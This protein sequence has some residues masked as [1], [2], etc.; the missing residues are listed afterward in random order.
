MDKKAYLEALADHVYEMTEE[1]I[2][3]IVDAYLAEGYS[4]YEAI[5]DG[6]VKGMERA[7]EAFDEEEYFVTDLLFAA[8][9]LYLALD[10]LK[11][12]IEQDKSLQKLGKIVIG[13]V[14]GDT[15]DIGKNLVKM[16]LEVAGFDMIDLGKDV[17]NELFVDTAIQE[18]A[19]IICMSSL[20]STTM[21]SMRT[22]IELLEKRGVRSQFKVMVGGGPV[23]DQFAREIGADGYSVNATEAVGLAKQLLQL[24]D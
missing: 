10:V 24:K 17:P 13:D 3:P 23:T 18:Q 8:D 21:D 7:G 16:M 6:L 2:L 4:A 1:E 9:T 12:H 5:N 20:M 19:Q 14:Q 11:P 22:V 15:H